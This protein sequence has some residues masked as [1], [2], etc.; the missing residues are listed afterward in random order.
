MTTKLN[1]TQ[2]VTFLISILSL[3]HTPLSARSETLILPLRLKQ[4]NTQAY[5][6]IASSIHFQSHLPRLSLLPLV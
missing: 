3:H 6:F 2:V 4:T 5:D 1:V